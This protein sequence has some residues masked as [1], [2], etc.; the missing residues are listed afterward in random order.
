MRNTLLILCQ[1]QWSW[2]IMHKT[3]I[4]GFGLRIKI[5]KQSHVLS[6]F[7]SLTMTYKHWL[8]IKL[9]K[10][11]LGVFSS[12]FTSLIMTCQPWLHWLLL[13]HQFS[14]L[15]TFHP[16]RHSIWD[17]F[18]VL[19]YPTKSINKSINSKKH[20]VLPC[21]LLITQSCHHFHS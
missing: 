7:A 11:S 19:I 15:V 14:N 18:H 16:T 8:L 10:H 9:H 4:W 12:N 20:W 17:Y 3:W 5:H 1:W 2:R 13:P 6:I 21:S